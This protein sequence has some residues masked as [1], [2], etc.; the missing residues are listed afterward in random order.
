MHCLQH[1]FDYS[2]YNM[3]TFANTCEFHTLFRKRII[4]NAQDL[5]PNTGVGTPNTEALAQ[6]VPLIVSSRHLLRQRIYC[7][8]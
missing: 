5:T 1:L 6:K 2:T 7:Q 3:F 4:Q 8:D